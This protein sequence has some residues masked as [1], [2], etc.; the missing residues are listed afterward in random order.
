MFEW[1][2][3]VCSSV[4]VVFDQSPDVED[5]VEHQ[6][7]YDEQFFVLFTVDAFVVPKCVVE[8]PF[9]SDED[10]GEDGDCVITTW[11]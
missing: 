7:A 1:D 3:F 8:V 4:V 11:Y 2:L 6:E 5:G 9:R 10:E